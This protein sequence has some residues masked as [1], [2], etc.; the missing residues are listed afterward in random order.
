MTTSDSHGAYVAKYGVLPSIAGADGLG[1]LFVGG[2]HMHAT[3][4]VRRAPLTI[5]AEPY[6]SS[7]VAKSPRAV[8]SSFDPTFM[9]FQRALFSDIEREFVVGLNENNF[10]WN[11]IHAL[12]EEIMCVPGYSMT[13]MSFVQIDNGAYRKQL[14]LSAGYSEVEARIAEEFW[15]LV[16]SE[17]DATNLNLP[18]I[19]VSGVRRFTYDPIWKA[20]HFGMITD[21][22][23]FEEMLDMVE[24]D[25]WVA[26]A[27][28]FEILSMM[29]MQT[30]A[31]PERISKE[32][33]V[34]SKDEALHPGKGK[35]RPADKRVVID[36]VEY[37][38]FSATR[39]RNVQAGPWA[40]NGSLQIIA[41]GTMRSMFRRWPSVFHVSTPEQIESLVNDHWVICGDV[42]EYDRSMSRDAIEM[43]FKC[44]A[45]KWDPRFV[46][47][48]RALM[49]APYYSR[50][51]DL[52]EN[53]GSFIGDPRRPNENEI[54]AGNRSGHAWTSLIAKGNKVIDDLIRQHH[55][56]EKVVGRVSALL[57]GR[58]LVKH[59]NNGDDAT[60]YSVSREAIA[61]IRAAFGDP[62]K[63]HYVVKEEIGQILS[64][65]MMI[66][67]NVAVPRYQVRNRAFASMVK[68]I[69]P[70]RAAGSRH[71]RMWPIGMLERSNNLN[72]WANPASDAGWSVFHHNWRKTMSPV[73]GDYMDLVRR[74][75]ESLPVLV[76]S[77]TAAD[78]DVLEN[79][80][81]IHYR[82]LPEEISPAVRN[83]L[84]SKI[85]Y[86]DFRHIPFRYYKGTVH[87]TSYS[88]AH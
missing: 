47:L 64:G 82:Y 77:L 23:N 6:T 44:A 17:W 32:R 61:D 41:A 57:E 27:D 80:E 31:Q 69:V 12:P 30:R 8:V 22:S 18:K 81:K 84:L 49:F 24:S 52:G 36:G 40:V 20:D 76:D 85:A 1:K 55:L 60:N 42:T 75:L 11:G 79:P 29:Y 14:G 62:K 16:F 5:I 38:D 54:C 70:E 68:A 88:D 26:L 28:K 13:P 74:A 39:A 86:A 67:E 46:K 51:L 48:A 65:F 53:R 15:D 35:G 63:G 7:N 78:R 21:V 56:G 3:P 34:F 71:R 37:P 10:S 87:E 73:Y 50:P 25:S 59:I 66:Q 19:S 4:L 72:P 43:V 45:K 2:N 33:I 9:K 83:E 58:G